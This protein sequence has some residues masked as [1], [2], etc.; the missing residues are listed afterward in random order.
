MPMKK[1]LIILTICLSAITTAS[2][3]D[4][5]GKLSFAGSLNYGSKVESLGIGLRAQYGFTNHLRGTA[6]YK[7]YIDRHNLSAF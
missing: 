1:I 4:Q 6:E 5:T 7:Y 2:A 3:Q